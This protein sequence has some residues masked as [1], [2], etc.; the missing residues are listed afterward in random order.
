MT[1]IKVPALFITGAV[2]IGFI[3]G[4]ILSGQVRAESDGLLEQLH[5]F[6]AVLK[7]V[8]RNYVEEV[9][10]QELVRGAIRGML[11]EL[12]P[13]STY[14]DP[15]A[16][17]RMNE[18]NTGEYEGIGISFEVRDG[19]ITVISAIEGGPSAHLG[20]RPGDQI[21]EIEGKSAR[22]LSNDEVISKLKGPKGSQVN[23][24][25]A[26]PGLNKH[27]HYTI[28][29]DT[30]PIYSVPYSFML[31]DGQTGY[32]RMIRFSAT[33]ADELE[34]ALKGLE[35]QG[36]TRL[37]LDLRSN[38]GGLLNQA[39]EVA[40]KFID[41]NQVI[42]YTKGR[43]EGSSQYYYSTDAATHPRYPLIVLV[44]HGSAS[45]SEIV[46][47][48]IQDHDRGLVTGV[49]T[50]GKGLVQRQYMLPDGSALLLTVARYYTPSGRL[51]QRSY[52]NRE[53][54]L[55]HWR[56]PDLA[57]SA[58]ADTTGKPRFY[59]IAEHRTVYGGGGITPDVTITA[60][61]DLNDAE[62]KIESSR[63]LFEFA[64]AFANQHFDKSTTDEQDFLKNYR[65]PDDELT[66][67]IKQA[68]ADTSVG[69]TV[70]ELTKEKEYIR[71]A[72]KR[73][74][75]GNLWGLNA[76]YQVIIKED[77]EV[78]EA[79]KYFPEAALMAKTYEEASNQN[80]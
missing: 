50:F 19:W 11:E 20:I 44:N 17:A 53:E 65:V 4:S 30:I 45:A 33:T 1:K 10:N 34:H 29:R 23:I 52:A 61:F 8:D 36:M 67:Y 5:V 15:E 73:E 16:F 71:T 22:G 60:S 51:I 64:N 9:D 32:V 79:M 6:N 39:I 2:L 46:S 80:R 37:I 76:R 78:A 27:L 31:D 7:Y 58:A 63:N 24:T 40:D 21:V 35:A 43:I 55:E 66:A 48:A 70:E 75:A 72:I 77:P 12:D 3:L 74:V 54:Y 25:V 42:V 28:T 56:Q 18:R 47:G 62:I 13:H 57:D 59:T 41:G 69:L 49:T 14:V 38:S 68:A 26:R